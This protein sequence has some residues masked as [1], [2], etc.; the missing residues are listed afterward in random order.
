[1]GQVGFARKAHLSG[2]GRGREHI[3]LGDERLFLFGQVD[4]GLVQDFVDANHDRPGLVVPGRAKG[5]VPA[6]QGSV[7][8]ACLSRGIH[9][10]VKL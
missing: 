9:H 2:M 6:D 3:G 7:C 10:L 1:M 5:R 8:R 4:G